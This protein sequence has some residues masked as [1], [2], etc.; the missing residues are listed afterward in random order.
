MNERGFKGIWMCAAVYLADDLT[1]IEKLLLVEIDSLTTA[2]CACY[3]GNHHFASLLHITESRA[4]HLLSG[5]AKRGYVIT[6]A[7]HR[8]MDVRAKK[9]VGMAL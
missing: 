6:Q 4:N 5:L 7:S 1:P 3:A 8:R 2:D 9:V